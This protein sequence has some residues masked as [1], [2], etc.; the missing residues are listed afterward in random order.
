MFVFCFDELQMLNLNKPYDDGHDHHGVD[1]R[2]IDVDDDAGNEL[3]A[4]LGKGKTRQER[5]MRL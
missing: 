5:V 4:G 1:E 2:V 3:V